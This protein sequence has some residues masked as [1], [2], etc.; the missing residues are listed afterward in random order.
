MDIT[1]DDDQKM[2]RE[3]AIAFAQKAMKP[4]AIRALEGSERGFDAMIWRQISEMGWAG[5]V[6]PEEYGGSGTGLLELALIVEAL[7]QGAVP[8]PIYSTVVEAGLLLLDAGSSA[9]R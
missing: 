5:A 2:L 1:I 3:T 4:E 7:G 9:Q 8:S 6:F